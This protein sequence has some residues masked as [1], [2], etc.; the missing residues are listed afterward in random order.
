MAATTMSPLRGR[1]DYSWPNGK[2]LAVYFALNLEHF[3]FGEGLGAELAPG[4]PHPDVLNYAWR[5]YGNRV[6]AWYLHDAFDALQ[7]PVAALVNSAMYDYAPE[8]VVGA[9]RARRRDRRP[10]PH[11]RRTPGHRSTRR[12]RGV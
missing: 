6:G 5:D 1:P 12:P 11:Q 2:R 4:G 10:R 9:S 8:L 7:L 3:S